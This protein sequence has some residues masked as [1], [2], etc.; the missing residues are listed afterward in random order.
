MPLLRAASYGAL[1]S[2]DL[3]KMKT[4]RKMIKMVVPRSAVVSVRRAHLQ[5][6]FGRA[7]KRFLRD[8][9]AHA[10]P[11]DPVLGD[12]IRGWG[13]EDWSALD[14]YL[15]ACITEVAVSAGPVLECG[16]GLSTLLAGAVAMKRGIKYTALEH[17]PDWA[18]R[19]RRSLET[20]NIKGVEL[21]VSP[22][23]DHGEFDWYD[24]DGASLP[25]PAL[26]I[27]DGPPGTTR[28]GR[29]GLASILKNRVKDG[30]L[31]L[32]DDA[33]RTQEI[34]IAHRW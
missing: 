25:E 34:E 29:Y 10:V 5:W 11:G 30:C 23:V 32:L 33:G 13:N 17:S 2:F 12:L 22:L 24:V 20:Y 1:P 8:P 16:S 6:I 26:I 15:S 7:M 9:E 21:I 4:V 18:E 31:I 27:C 28:G 14:E 19:V 3:G